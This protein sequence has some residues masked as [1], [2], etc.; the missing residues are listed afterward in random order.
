V[1]GQEETDWDA[2]SE[3]AERREELNPFLLRGMLANALRKRGYGA[4]VAPEDGVPQPPGKRFVPNLIAYTALWSF[5]VSGAIAVGAPWYLWPLG[6]GAALVLILWLNRLSGDSGWIGSMVLL[7]WVILGVGEAIKGDFATLIITYLAPLGVGVAYGIAT[8]VLRLREAQDLALALGGVIKSAPL[9]APVVLVVLF[10][11][12]LSA[13]VWQVAEKLTPTS[14][15]IVGVSSVGLLFIVVRLQ[16]GSETER[17]VELRAKQLCDQSGRSE[18]TRRQLS[19][20][21]SDS[22]EA[23]LET[24]ADADLESAWPAAGEEYAPYL[25]AAGGE[26]LLSPLTGRLALTIGIVGILFSAYIYLLCAAVVPASLAAEWTGTV[27]P[28]T[29]LELAGLE[30]TLHGGAFLNLAALMGLAATATF[31]S[32]ALIE[33]RFAKAL[34]GALLQDPTDR[35]LVLALPYVSLWEEAI[36]QGRAAR[37]ADAS[38]A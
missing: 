35:L 20:A 33:E 25:Q 1:S 13:D 8:R 15:L 10:L 14:L 16:L 22:N 11:P 6:I 38:S 31:L 27:A 5:G 3:F 34:A 36:E 17:T 21:D 37:Q 4:I 12:A 9:V 32:F 24:M 28:S 30:L 18:L 2:L 23:L 26:T 29:R 7:G 19:A